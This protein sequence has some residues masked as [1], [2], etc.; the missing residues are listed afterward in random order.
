MPEPFE[1]EPLQIRAISPALFQMGSLKR[2]EVSEKISG[3]AFLVLPQLLRCVAFLQLPVDDK[4]EDVATRQPDYRNPVDQ[5]R[6]RR[7][8]MRRRTVFHVLRH[9]RLGRLAQDARVHR[10]RIEPE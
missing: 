8:D 3:S 6:R 10:L 5:K 9:P 7:A 2:Y 4:I 1:R